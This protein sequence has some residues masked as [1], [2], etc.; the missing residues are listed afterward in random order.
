MRKGHK[1]I[2]EKLSRRNLMTRKYMMQHD[3]WDILQQWQE[4]D[5]RKLSEELT[6]S[7]NAL[8][9]ETQPSD[10]DLNYMKKDRPDRILI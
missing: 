9:T 2:D 1:E 4:K 8:K 10:F 5:V 6:M 7:I 3:Q